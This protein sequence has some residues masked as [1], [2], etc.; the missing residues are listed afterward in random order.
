M[1]EEE[2]GS[3]LNSQKLPKSTVSTR[4]HVINSQSKDM[5][6]QANDSQLQADSGGEASKS[7]TNEYISGLDESSASV[8]QLDIPSQPL[9]N[10]EL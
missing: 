2:G 3:S 4:K 9:N 8:M 6:I 1:S 5:H 10:Q 7:R